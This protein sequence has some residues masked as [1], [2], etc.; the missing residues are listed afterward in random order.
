MANTT[1][2]QYTTTLDNTEQRDTLFLSGEEESDSQTKQI[3]DDI[4]NLDV[5]IQNLQDS[6]KRALE[7]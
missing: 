7:S 2:Q 1:E 4:A 5:E 3:K 6:L